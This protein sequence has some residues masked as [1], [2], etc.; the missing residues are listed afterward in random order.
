MGMERNDPAQRVSWGMLP[1]MN[2]PDRNAD[3][4]PRSSCDIPRVPGIHI[5][6]SAHD[7]GMVQIPIANTGS[8]P[9]LTNMDFTSP[10]HAP[11]DQDQD[12]S[13][14]YSSSDKNI[15]L[16]NADFSQLGA[17]SGMYQQPGSPASPVQLP[18]MD[19]Y[20]SSRPSPQP[21]PTLGGRH[22]APCSPGEP[23]PL[24]NDY[25]IHSQ[26][27]QFQQHFEQLTVVS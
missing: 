27:M 19:G 6:P 7:P 1:N 26:N 18:Q 10:I 9:D 21:S 13:S 14:P 24:Q 22:S 11:L 8:L 5:Y 4:R 20:R 25:H 15:A 3:G 16:E 2:G 17:L 12:N 23:S